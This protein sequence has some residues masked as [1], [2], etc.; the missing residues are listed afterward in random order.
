MSTT[1]SPQPSR[2]IDELQAGAV[3]LTVERPRF[4][5]AIGAMPRGRGAAGAARGPRVRRRAKT[6]V[7]RA[8]LGAAYAAGTA[9]ATAAG[10][11]LVT[12]F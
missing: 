9:L 6:L 4:G 7:W 2:P 10:H 1:S 3:R 5:P 12:W 11:W 8:A